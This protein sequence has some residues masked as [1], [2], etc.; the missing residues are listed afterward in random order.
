MSGR[1]LRSVPLAVGISAAMGLVALTA[2]GSPARSSAGPTTSSSVPALSSVSATPD[3]AATSGANTIG[4]VSANAPAQYQ[5]LVEPFDVAGTCNEDGNTLEMTACALE[6]VVA[7]DASVDALQ[8][9]QF[10]NAAPDQREDLLADDAQWLKQRTST[11]A[12]QRTGGTIDQI[13][14]AYCLL[15][16]SQRRVLALG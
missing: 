12:A 2:C 15:K 1:R 6:Q 11:C 9:K 13:N 3:T 16:E 10:E 4:S 7:V 14:G 5:K 8:R